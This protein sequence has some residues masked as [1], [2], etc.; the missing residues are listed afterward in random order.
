LIPGVYPQTLGGKPFADGTLVIH[1]TGP[2]Y[3]IGPQYFIT[4]DIQVYGTF[5]YGYKGPLIDTAVTPLNPIKPETVTMFEAGIKSSWFDHRLTVNLTAF[6]E[7][8]K[9]LQVTVWNINIT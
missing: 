7:D 1:K 5:A 9:N 6:N 2:T 3:H 8:Y 4:P